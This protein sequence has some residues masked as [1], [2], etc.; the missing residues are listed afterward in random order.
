MLGQLVV[1]AGP[2]EGIT[3]TLEGGQPLLVG[4]G[5]NTGTKLKDPKVSRLH[6]EIKEQDGKLVL[7]D[8]GSTGGTL[9]NGK[10]VTQHTLRA[11]DVIQ[12][13]GTQLRVDLTGGPDSTTMVDF[14]A[15]PPTPTAE[16]TDQLTKLVGETLSHYRIDAVLSRAASGMVFAAHDTKANRK[17]AL[18]VLWP[19]FSKNE[20]EKQRFIRAMKTML[21]LRHPNLV[22]L[23]GAGKS[24]PYCWSAM[25]YVDGEDLTHVIQQIGTAG[26]LDWRYSLRVAVHIARALDYAQEHH[27]IHRNIKPANIMVQHS[28][29][30]A[31]LGDLM[32][33][34]ALEG[35]QAEQITRPGQL[36][37]D[38]VYMSPERTRGGTATVDGRSD[39]YSLGA[40]VYA[41][42]TGRPPFDAG[43]LAETIL[44]IR[45]H[46]PA[47]P[48]KYQLSI[49]DLFEGTIKK[50]L[51]KRPE[52]RFQTAGEL[53]A[54][55]ERVA[56]YQGLSI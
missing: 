11:N 43:S 20:E 25:E 2:D 47:S 12:I 22:E 17:V 5:Q 33:A 26:M 18:K 51:A 49:P 37:G 15:S 31:K 27:I 34:K 53:L 36:V 6:C 16:K 4:R 42:L 7:F 40:T 21:P 41:L 19:E 44:Q 1:V 30:L 29:K 9:V 52:D 24:G 50:M 14:G 10:R 45:Q 28:D 23:Y 38:V 54:E 55:L 32:L 13:G 8:S 39:I 56:K 48:K 3:F 46:E 35:T